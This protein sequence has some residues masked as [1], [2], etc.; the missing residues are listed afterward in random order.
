[1]LRQREAKKETCHEGCSEPIKEVQ[2]PRVK[3]RSLEKRGYG[4]VLI[5]VRE[6][7]VGAKRGGYG[8]GNLCSGEGV[9][10]STWLP[11]CQAVSNSVHL[12]RNLHIEKSLKKAGQSLNLEVGVLKDKDAQVPC[13]VPSIWLDGRT[14]HHV[15]GCP[16][17]WVL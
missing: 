11:A 12:T 8:S 14:A 4:D 6:K 16:P 3:E 13:V 7:A 15:H 10:S 17:C 9:I 1:M 2:S 5:S